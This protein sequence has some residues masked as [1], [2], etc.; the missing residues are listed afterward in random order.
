MSKVSKL[1]PV[2]QE[3]WNKVN[4]FNKFIFED[5]IT[6]STEL[7]PKTKIAYESNLKIWFIWVKDNLNNKSQIDIK[8]LDFKRFQN[9]MVNRGCSSA[10][11]ANKRAAIS[12]LNNYIDVYYRD[13]Y[14]QF[15]NFINKSIAR[16]PKA[17]VNE[18]QPLT[19]EE[20]ANLISV[21]EKRGDWQKVAY[22]KFTLD[23]GCRRAESIQVKKDFVNIKPTIK[24]KTHIDENG[25][26]VTKEIKYYVTPTIRCKG[27]GTVGKERKF[28]FSQDTMDAF[29]KWIEVRGE[30]DCPDMFISKYAGKVKGIAENTLNNWATHVFTP[31]V[32]R[33]FHPHLLRE[34][35]ATQLAVEEGKDISVI[36]SLLGHES[37]ETTQI[38]IIRDETDDLDEL[39]EE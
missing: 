22:L 33:R 3:E 20:F 18:K 25:N 7:S 30:D 27:K 38:Y 9:W 11:C 35:K 37:S 13:D 12:S 8:P 17:F 6:N 19:K 10:D 4:D 29:K 1:P 16:P 2:T 14:P 15:R 5:F 36:Q 23:T 24:H 31:I 26:D 39:F 32:G 28:K 34:S 21:L